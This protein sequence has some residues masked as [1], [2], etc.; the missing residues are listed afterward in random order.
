MKANRRVDTRQEVLLRSALH[1][2]GLRFRKDVYLRVGDVR[3]KADIVFSR[4]RIAVYLDGC[5][6]HRCPEHGQLPKAN[7]DYWKPKLER[8]AQR[9]KEAT[10]A[11]RAEGWTVIRIWEHEPIDLAVETIYKAVQKT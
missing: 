5:F 1:R 6:W 8:N 10:K 7:R 4:H 9:D 2:R 11:L 3:T